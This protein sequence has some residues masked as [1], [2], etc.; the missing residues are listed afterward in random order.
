MMLPN[1]CSAPG[2]K[3]GTPRSLVLEPLEIELAYFQSCYICLEIVEQVK[4]PSVRILYIIGGVQLSLMIS[5]I[6]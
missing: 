4:N 5:D 6:L 1:D 2:Q 3:D